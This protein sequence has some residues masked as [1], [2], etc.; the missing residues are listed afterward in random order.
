MPYSVFVLSLVATGIIS[1]SQSG[2]DGPVGIVVGFAIV[3]CTV[4]R[5]RLTSEK[6]SI[7][8]RFVASHPAVFAGSGLAVSIL[9]LFDTL[10]WL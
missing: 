9:G 5:T 7:I 2:T 6:A 8:Q 1:R 10:G 3:A 4:A